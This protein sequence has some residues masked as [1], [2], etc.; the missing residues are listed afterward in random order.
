[1]SPFRNTMRFIYRNETHPRPCQTR[2]KLVILESLGRN[3]KQFDPARDGLLKATSLLVS[4]N[5]AVDDG[6]R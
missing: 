5:R 1:M 4:R 3:V 6:R 2:S